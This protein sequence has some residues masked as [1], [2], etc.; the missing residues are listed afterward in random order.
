MVRTQIQLTK[1]QAEG[2]KD[3]AAAQG[4]SMADLVRD[5]VDALLDGAGHVS[6]DDLKKRA[7]AVVGRLHGG[8][9]DL[10]IRHDHYLERAQRTRRR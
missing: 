1:T 7:L 6:R 8:P 10:S 9:R 4:R 5:S 2:L 3:L